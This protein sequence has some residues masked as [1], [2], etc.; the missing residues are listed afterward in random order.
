LVSDYSQ[1]DGL[2]F[3]TSGP[4]NIYHHVGKFKD[5]LMEEIELKIDT[6]YMLDKMVQQVKVVIK[7]GIGLMVAQMSSESK[8]SSRSVQS[9][10]TRND[11]IVQDKQG[12]AYLRFFKP[13]RAESKMLYY[14]L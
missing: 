12:I 4:I 8:K 11:I 2:L 13:F 1:R 9:T 10:E 5:E 6:E 7:K 14:S 3:H